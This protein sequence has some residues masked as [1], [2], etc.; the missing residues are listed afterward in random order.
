MRLPAELDGVCLICE[1]LAS[2]TWGMRLETRYH[3]VPGPACRRLNPRDQLCGV[4]LGHAQG[5]VT[6]LM[7]SDKGPDAKARSSLAG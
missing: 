4:D 6:W 2:Y 7:K 5:L 3:A 1:L